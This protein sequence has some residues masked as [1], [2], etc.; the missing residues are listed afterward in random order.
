MSSIP[1]Q[2]LVYIISPPTCGLTPVI[3]SLNVSSN[4]QVGVPVHF[5]ISAATL[6]NPNI[7]NI[8]SIMIAY[9][10]DGMQV[11]N[12]SDYPT[13]ASVSYATFIWT[14]TT[15]QIGLQELCVVAFSE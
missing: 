2:F 15:N 4:V 7:S 9:G 6:C 12:A 3:L 1:V 14:P 5:N 13:N 8:D 11:S 10:V